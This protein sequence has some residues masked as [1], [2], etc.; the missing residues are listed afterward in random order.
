MSSAEVEEDAFGSSSLQSAVAAIPGIAESS[1][2]FSFNLASLDD[3]DDEERGE[4]NPAHRQ[5]GRNNIVRPEGLSATTARKDESSPLLPTKT[6]TA[7]ISSSSSLRS[8]TSAK[9][10]RPRSCGGGLAQHPPEEMKETLAPIALESFQWK[11]K[12]SYSSPYHTHR[13]TSSASQPQVTPGYRRDRYEHRKQLFSCGLAAMS[14]FADVLCHHAF[15]CY[16]NMMTGNTIRLMDLLSSG[17]WSEAAYPAV[18]VPSYILGASLCTYLSKLDLT[19]LGLGGPSQQAFAHLNPPR[20]LRSPQQIS[21]LRVVA[22]AAAVLFLQGELFAVAALACWTRQHDHDKSNPAAPPDFQYWRLPFFSCAFGLLNAATLSAI[23]L[24]TN[25]VT[26]HWITVGLGVADDL[27]VLL[28]KQSSTVDGT[29]ID[30]E[31][32][33]QAPPVRIQTPKATAPRKKWQSSMF[34]AASFIGSIAITSI[35]YNAY[36]WEV[37]RRPDGWLHNVVKH[38]PMGV[39]FAI[40]Y[41]VLLYWYTLPPPY[42]HG[43]SSTRDLASHG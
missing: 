21:V 1:G 13:R 11:K 3:D 16:G 30:G 33:Y 31:A 26:G 5:Q 34:L 38:I 23:H 36:L 29:S 22:I 9:A 32:S 4:N 17:R 12:Q 41:L 7:S 10:G 15:G 14:G 40:I 39:F 27:P 6:P 42:L 8:S 19:V 43:Y 37:D 24:V 28:N 18:L 25:A 35:L 20:R 2:D